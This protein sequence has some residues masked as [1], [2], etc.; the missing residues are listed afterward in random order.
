[1]N[2]LR[3]IADVLKKLKSA[4]IFTH[5]RPD[6]DTIGGAMALSCALDRLGIKNEVVNEA[7]IPQKYM[8]LKGTERIKTTPEIE[9]QALICIDTSDAARVGALQ[10][11]YFARAKK[12][13][14]INVDHHIS[15]TRYAQYNFVRERSSNCENVLELIQSM[16]APLD[17]PIAEFL[18]MGMVTDSGGFSHSDVNG[19][20]MRAAALCIDAGASVQKITYEAYKKQTLNRAK[21]YLAALETLRFELDGKLSVVIVTQEEMKRYGVLQDATEGIVDF[22]LSVDTVE[23]SV[24]LLEMKK[25]Q[26]KVS[27]RSQGK[28]NVNE[29]AQAFGGGGH[30]LAAGCMLFG[31]T[32]ELIDKLVYSTKQQLNL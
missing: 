9:P 21:F 30:V 17:K 1:M 24:C 18:L 11:Y 4:V 23:V 8:F 20:T 28:A 5:M 12:S 19:D 6:G 27:L 7:P 2:S 26:Y 22:G 10:E 14:T 32:E 25:G 13:I 16:G 31:D 3:E 15:N 29:M